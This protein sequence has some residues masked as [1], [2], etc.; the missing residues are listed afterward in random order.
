MQ[1]INVR[2]T[3]NVLIGYPLAGVFDRVLAFIIDVVIFIAY[4]ILVF[5]VLGKLEMASD[6]IFT[7][8]Y[9]PAFF[10]NLIFEITMNGQSPG[11]RAMQIKVVRLD[12]SQP[13]IANYIMRFVLW[14]IDVVLSGSIA[15]TFILLT[16]NSQRLGDLAAGTTVVKLTKTAPISSQKIL[17]NM[18]DGYVPEFP[19]VVHLSDSDISIIREALEANVQMGNEKPIY[20]LADKIKKLHGIQS[21]L[22]AAQFLY[23]VLKEYQY[24][25]ANL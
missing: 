15:I 17:E 23:T 14:P 9:L 12:G 6:W 2:T 8:I 16:K 22:P 10:Y 21:D 19:Q 11:K 18:K 24:I 25:T 1:T 3:Q 20:L 7:L 4:L 13:T 5:F